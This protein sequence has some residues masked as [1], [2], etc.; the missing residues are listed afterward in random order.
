MRKTKLETLPLRLDIYQFA[1]LANWSTSQLWNVT[2]PKSKK[3]DP[4]APPRR[5]I[6]RSTRFDTDRCWAWITATEGNQQAD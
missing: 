4:T 6:G 3:F 5:K 1:E 2:N